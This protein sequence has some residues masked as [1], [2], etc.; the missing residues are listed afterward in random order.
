MIN[1][2]ITIFTPRLKAIDGTNRQ[3]ITSGYP[4]GC[5]ESQLK[6]TRRAVKPCRVSFFNL[7]IQS[8]YRWLFKLSAQLQAILVGSDNCPYWAK[9][10]SFL[11]TFSFSFLLQVFFSLSFKIT[12][13]MRNN[14]QRV[15]GNHDSSVRHKGGL[16]NPQSCVLPL[17]NY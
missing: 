11:G 4:L 17:S 2:L 13:P 9:R 6:N 15:S 12:N 5:N 14:I 16:L 8:S 7:I 1:K 10:E 3:S